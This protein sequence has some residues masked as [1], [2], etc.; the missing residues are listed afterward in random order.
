LKSGLQEFDIY[1]GGA[2]SQITITRY[3]QNGFYIAKQGQPSVLYPNPIAIIQ[4]SPFGWNPWHK[5]SNSPAA[6]LTNAR[7][8][9]L[10]QWEPEVFVAINLIRPRP[11]T[12]QHF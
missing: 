7:H 11:G 9:A 3:T 5:G 4:G 6:T 10:D 2:R 12:E 1:S 8:G